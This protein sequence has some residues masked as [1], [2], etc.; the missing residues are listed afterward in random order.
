MELDVPAVQFAAEREWRGS[1]LIVGGVREARAAHV[2]LKP[3]VAARF[4]V[5]ADTR[6]ISVPGG[7]VDFGVTS[8]HSAMVRVAAVDIVRINVVPL[9]VGTVEMVNEIEIPFRCGILGTPRAGIESEVD[10]AGPC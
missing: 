6:H 4:A 2:E 5:V 8:E 3:I 9:D 7:A 1:I 10:S